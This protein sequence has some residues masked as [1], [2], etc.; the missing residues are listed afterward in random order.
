MERREF[1]RICRIG[2]VA[3]GASA[4]PLAARGFWAGGVAPSDYLTTFRR[5]LRSADTGT[6]PLPAVEKVVLD[7]TN[8]RRRRQ[9]RDPLAADPPLADVARFYAHLLAR[10]A[11]FAHRDADGRDPQTR[12]NILHRRLIGPTGENLFLSNEIPTDAADRAGR[13]AVDR[14]MTSPGH[15]ENILSRDWTHAG[16][17][18]VASRAGVLYA[19]QL[20]SHR[21][22]L[23]AE[24]LPIRLQ[25]GM[26]APPEL[27]RFAAGMAERIAFI[28][29]DRALSM[30]DFVLLDQVRTPGERGVYRCH[31]AIV[32]GREGLRISYAVHPGPVVEVI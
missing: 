17:G 26:P 3:G 31:Y 7:H 14:L 21:A 13:N 2:L 5:W 19:V 6:T 27:S 1:L 20:F 23:L 9:G 10:G 30:E 8:G 24:E 25:A 11:P 16:M 4:V 32:T 15:R 22:L 18:A 29:D 28:P 12:I